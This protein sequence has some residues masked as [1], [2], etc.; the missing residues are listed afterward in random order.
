M[1]EIVILDQGTMYNTMR[2]KHFSIKLK[3]FI[4]KEE[5]MNLSLKV[6]VRKKKKK[7]SVRC[8]FKNLLPDL[9]N[10]G[11]FQDT[12]G[13]KCK[14]SAHIEHKHFPGKNE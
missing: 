8:I 9:N 6:S 11:T 4:L 5:T 1:I 7:V 12:K 2:K 14:I 13:N 10:L 3:N